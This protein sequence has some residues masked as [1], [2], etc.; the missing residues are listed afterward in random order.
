MNTTGVKILRYTGFVLLLLSL[1]EIV[2]EIFNVMHFDVLGL[3]ENSAVSQLLFLQAGGFGVQMI[4]SVVGIVAGYV[5]L[6]LADNDRFNSY[7]RYF[8]TGLILI[9]LIEGIMMFSQ[10]SAYNWVRLC[11]ML[12]LSALYLYGAWLLGKEDQE[13]MKQIH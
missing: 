5:A 12:I 7:L 2:F 6:F 3:T 10:A 11:V 1:I 8:G 9:Y 13:A 4:F